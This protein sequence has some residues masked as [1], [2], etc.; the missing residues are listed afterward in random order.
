MEHNG[1][2]QNSCHGTCNRLQLICSL[3]QGA[4]GEPSKR[5]MV[6][7]SQQRH[8]FQTYFVFILC[9]VLLTL[10]P[11]AFAQAAFVFQPAVTVGGVPQLQTVP[12]TIQ[13]TG[14]LGTVKVLTQGSPNLDFTLSSV[15]SCPTTPGQVCDVSVSFLPKY[16]GV[17]FG[18][19]L[20]LDT[21]GNIMASQNISG[22]GAGSLSVMAPGEINI[23][24]GDGCLS[25]GPCPASGS[26]QATQSAINLPLGEATDAA[27]NLYISDT[28]NNR[29]EKVDLS[30]NI[31][32]IAGTSEV[33]G[34]AG[35]GGLAASA[36]ISAPS[37]I[38]V[39]GAGNI[40]FADT[41]NNA[42]RE[43]NVTTHDISTIAGTLGTAGSTGTLLSAPQGFA[44]D[45]V[46]DLYIADTGNNRI[47]KIDTA[48]NVTTVPGTYDQPWGVTVGLDGSLYIAD[49]GSNRILKVDSSGSVTT[50]V[51][52]GTASYTGDG[53]LAI[54]ATM[55][56]PS[57][58]MIDAAGNL[59]IA[60]SENNAIRK[61][62]YV[63]GKISTLAG[64]GTA[65]FGG[66]GFSANLAGLYKP[67]SVYLDGAGDLF[68]ADRLDLRIRE[69]S[70]TLAGIQYPT[71]KE[72]KTSAPIAQTVEN[73]GNA[74]LNLTNLSAAP[75]TMN[76]ALDT[77]STDPIR[78]TCST[79][80]P[81]AIDGA[82][83]L[84]VEFTPVAVGSPGTGVLSI[85]SD[86]GSSPIAVDLTGTVLSIDPSSTTVTSS[87]NPAAVN[88]GVTFTAH[89]SSPNQVTGTVQFFDGTNA[90]GSPQPVASAS[91]TATL[92]YAFGAIGSHSITAVYSGDNLNA[93]S[94]PN[95]A[96]TQVIQQAT[97]LNVIPSANP[98]LQFASIT[99]TAN[100]SGWTIAPT[101]SITFT[102]GTTPLG[103]ATINSSGVASFPV[104]PLAVG[105]HTIAAVFAGD[106]ND[107][108]SQYSFTETVNLALSSTTLTSSNAVAQFSTPITFTATV[109]GVPASTPTGNVVFKDG[110]AVLNT[111]PVN[112][113][114][115]ATYVNST[116]P[117]GTHTITAVYQG[118]SDYAA[119]TSTQIVT[120]TI[121][122]TAT[123][124]AISTSTT[125]SISGRSVT[126]TATVTALENIP[127]GTV[128]FMN[129]STLIGTGTLNKGIA[130]VTTATLPIGTNNVTAVYNGDSNDTASTSSIVAI[131]IVQ[132]PT[133]TIVSS[134]QSPL[135]TL[136]PVVISATVSNGG[137]QNPT[138][139]VT[140]LEDSVSIGVGTLNAGGVATV[141]IPFLTAGSHNFI[142]TYAGD[143]L[144][145]PSSSASFI[146]VVQLR[147][148]TDVLTA[149]ASSLTGGQQLTLISV[150][151]PVGSVGSSAP[152][153]TVT[154]MSGNTTLATVPVDGTG[155]A[156]VTVLLSG[157]SA[158]LSSTYNGDTNYLGSSS[159]VTTVPIGPAPDFTLQANPTSWSMQSTQHL[160][161]NLTLTSVKNFTDNFVLGCQGLPQN[162][163]C[164]FSQVKTNLPA[165]GAQSV[166]LVVDTG[167][168]LLGGTQASNDHQSNSR[169]V[170]A[171]LFPGSL[172]FCFLAFRI[173]RVQP[174]SGL[175][176]L[177]GLF[178]IASGLSG[179]GSIQNS[180]TPPGT[181]N[182][183]VTATGQTGVSQFVNM[184]MTITK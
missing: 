76:A 28:G 53:G 18:S 150:V 139:L 51:G 105:N 48:G 167:D 86:S 179:C 138:G 165:G 19:V 26:T 58:V 10:S 119:S 65:L 170:F 40:F 101:G 20:I 142:A 113:F 4:T 154:F 44:F 135:P 136:T 174:I 66:D 163:N 84:A 130:S 82:C 45:A 62:N 72:G 134:S 87:L 147:A 52:T 68:I 9:L 166:T 131:T 99:F 132:A 116:L 146:Q 171:C 97:T 75:A 36:Q 54:D 78:T 169:V 56:S 152:T 182:F 173:R 155:V 149:S 32:T 100:L 111:V 104:P 35:D 6:F 17:R 63:T 176:L 123:N 184:T 162:A 102:D 118:N 30:G 70:A 125:N 161:I 98:V 25:D 31:S 46:G 23:L 175:L 108:G 39:D 177:V 140:F 180:G 96:L 95:T 164:N 137:A 160:S 157:T 88:S 7:R 49:F 69:V 85:T 47:R 80:Q 2:G 107:F 94:I 121:Q 129:G 42:I 178:V 156:T 74:Q 122:E 133:T 91:D 141:S 79:S 115:V 110:A 120:E 92:L 60:D 64:N 34:S 126:L 73:D 16:P 93:A 24:A 128:R 71:M 148:T 29:I 143:A 83:I 106:A 27:G 14:T 43:I 124:T 12:V 15:G 33:A 38:T 11:R 50:V 183:L 114:G 151:H 181:Y 59:Y 144:D 77:T 41:G 127:S 158:I 13:T 22:T 57:S 103:S 109:T 153:G 21:N 61:V 5:V 37:A 55:N 1:F 3:V 112:T 168:P 159:S 145:I 172:A 89:I 90:I 67:Y 8:S 81:L 117:A